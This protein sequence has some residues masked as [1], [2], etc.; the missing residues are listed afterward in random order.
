MSSTT[1]VELRS[2]TWFKDTTKVGFIHRSHLHALGFP[3][4]SF[5]G[6]RPVI[7]I[8]NTWSELNPCNSNLRTVAD[9][10]K[11]GVWE[12]GGL[13]LEFPVLSLGEP[14]LRPTSM[15]YRNLLAIDTEEMLRANPVDAAVLLGGCDKTLPGLVMGAASVDMPVAVVT[16]GPALNGQFEGCDI[17]S[18]TDIWRYS[19]DLRAGRID[20][21]T[22]SRVEAGMTRT[23]GHCMTMGTASTMA[24]LVEAMGLSLPGTAD[25]SAVDG[26][27]LAIAHRVGRLMVKQASN[28]QARPTTLITKQSLHNAIVVNAA[29]GGS[30]NAVVHL[31]ALAGRVGVDL[32]LDDFDAIG[33][34]VPLLVNL[35]PS[36]EFLMEEFH[37]AGGLAAVLAELLRHGLIDADAM[38]L[39]GQTI[40]AV[41]ADA[42]C[43]RSDVI[44]SVADPI[45]QAG[46]I[47]VLHGN[48]APDGAVIK[49]SAASPSL[50]Q[51]RGPAV[52][53][54]SIE[55][56][57]AAANDEIFAVG[58]DSVLVCRNLGPKGYPG[59]PELGNLPIPRS[60]ARR[61]ITDMVRI[62]DARM[63]G[64]AFGTVVLHAAPE[65]A[66]GGP[67]ALVQTG[68]M[69][70][71]DVDARRL[72]L[73]VDDD[74]LARRRHDWQPP[75]LPPGSER[76][77][78]RIYTDH[79]LQ[80]DR[81]ADLDICVGA[82]GAAVPKTP[83]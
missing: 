45:Q 14:F 47:A 55:E 11:R 10:V 28:D 78:S 22:F 18:G 70:E 51:H 8:A 38:T 26:R 65:S 46:A 33:R 58:D 60:N 57:L 6:S 49:V 61:G 3:A 25:I 37:R 5:D 12:A 30:T 67:L 31:L 4:D 63:S 29:I 66:V 56:Y 59:M 72:I 81:G 23:P 16:S 44:A 80:A 19:E 40:G 54:D 15:L 68:D 36:G 71:L 17:G 77:W 83:F 42:P 48:L 75:P 1:P 27:R 62:S 34:R 43:Y 69:I 82:S 53:F 73:E 7:G 9:A 76:G 20:E 52:V 39:T 2:A 41:Y 79:V 35:K 74:E 24:C 50:L 13:P 21:E 64:T 32:R